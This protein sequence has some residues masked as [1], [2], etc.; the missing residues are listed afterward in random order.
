M[1]LNF[2]NNGIFPDNAQLSFGTDGDL[3]IKHDGSNS[4][5][6]NN[7]GHLYI[8]NEAAD[9][10]IY[11]QTDDGS[12]GVTTYI[13]LDGAQ[14]LTEI[15]KNTKHMDGVYA[16]FGN[17]ADAQ[18]YHN[19]SDTWYFM[20]SADNGYIDFRNDDGSGSMTSYLVIDGN[21]ELNRFYKRVQLE[22]NVKLTL[23][24]ITDQDLQIYHDG[25]NSYIQDKGTGN[26][27]ITSDGAS[28]QINKGLTENMAEFIVDGAV[29]LYY[30][31]AKK[32]ETT[33]NGATITG[34][35]TTT[36]S[37][38]I[39]GINMTADI[40]MGSN[41]ITDSNSSAGTAGQVLSSLGAGNGTD[42]I[43]VSGTISGSG[44]NNRLVIWSGT[45]TITSDS[46]FYVDGDTIFTTNLEATTN[47]TAS[48]KLVT[49]EVESASTLL[50][51][52]TAD[53]TIDAGGSDIILSDDGTIFGTISS[54]SGTNL[55][56]R[57][58]IDNADMFFRGVDDGTE[59]NA[60]T[61]DMSAGGDATFAGN[62]NLTD[63]KYLNFGASQD[64]TISHTGSASEILNYTGNL[65]ITQH[66][67]DGDII[68]KSDDGSGG[69][70]AYITLDGSS[71][72][73][74]IPDSIPL[75]FGAGDDLQIQ[76]NGSQSYIQNFTGDLQIQ[77]N[78]DD[79]DVLLRCD[80]GSGGLATYMYLDG[81]NTRVQFNKDARF[82]DDKKVMLGTGDDLKIYHDGTNSYISNSTGDLYIEQLHDDGDIYFKSDDG[83]GGTATYFRVDGGATKVIASKNFAFVDDIKAEFGDSGD[84]QIY[85]DGSNSYIDETGTG[86]LY[87]K[88]AGAIRLQSDTGENMIYAV[89]DGAVNL[90]HNNVKHLKLQLQGLLL[91]AL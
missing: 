77:N 59:F 62:V 65:E 37:S 50:L 19:G 6:E 83:A 76:H 58:R 60:L 13:K 29:N 69:T 34:G 17:S 32:L 36:A 75:C 12:G 22:D 27:L 68:F 49:T 91:Q 78:A 86:S 3:V 85:H 54:G 10:S 88:S 43:D 31:S 45:T 33:T 90:Y 26:L 15:S 89:N 44:V 4:K 8:I 71:N 41:D 23:G 70:T 63:S 51:D 64:L 66:A 1:P 38:D 21:N 87:I 81:G 67:D 48:G 16:F 2:L 5:L 72:R 40:A 73:I 61:L 42:W 20:Q 14:E 7:T 56:I 79:G 25:S 9:K 52:A 30:D 28:V 84:L 57:S 74:D 82:V 24:N 47:I 46:D 11:F 53:I 18:I 80:D 55:Q 39:A 35:L